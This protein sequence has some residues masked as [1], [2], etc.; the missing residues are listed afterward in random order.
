[1]VA[2]K[3]HRS[4]TLLAL[5]FGIVTLTSRSSCVAADTPSPP[6]STR[7]AAA[8]QEALHGWWSAALK[9]RDQRLAWWRDA[10]FGC[11]IHWGAYSRLGG[12]FED[13]KGGTYSEH[14]MRQL[15]IPLA[16]YKEKVV[17]PF[18][19]EKFDADEWVALIKSAGMRYVVITAKHHDGFAMWPSDAYK[20]D[21]RDNTRFKRDPMQ[22]LSAAC[23]RAGIHFGF[24]YSHA[25]DWEHPDAPGN[26]WDYQNPG[27]DKHLFGDKQWYDL[28]PDILDRVQHYVDQKAI[29]QLQELITR[30]HPEIFWFDTAGK[31]PPSEQIR[32]VKAVRLAD[33][34]VVI[35]G[36][37]AR[38]G[39]QNFGDYL[40]TGDNPAEVR[41]TAGDWECIPTVNSS[42]GYNKFDNGYKTPEFFVQLLV[43]TVA[44]GGNMLLNIGPMGDGQID[45]HAAE[46]LRGIG[47]WMAVNGE[48]IHGA[49]RTP[50]E[51]QAWGDST[52]KGSTLYLHVLTWTADDRLMVGG[53]QN[54]VASAYFLADPHKTPLATERINDKDIL[55][56]LPAPTIPQPPDTVIVL[57]CNGPIKAA[58]G[59]LLATN[60]PENQLLAFD[61]KTSTTGFKYGDGKADRYYLA[62]FRHNTD[63]V[64][65]PIRVD[66][67]ATFN[68]SLKYS[69]TS[70]QQTGTYQLT[71]G[72]QTLEG[73]V[74][75]TNDKK[76]RTVHLGQLT[77]P[78]GEGQL[79]LRPTKIEGGDLMQLFEIT[80]TPATAAGNP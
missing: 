65:W 24:Y 77:F 40:D 70:P 44:K 41:P 27:G 71:F 43:K 76:P 52:I 75:P 13:H 2:R 31:L 59:R 23:H 6:P 54:D 15:K 51:R 38:Q 58:P 57:Q 19:P 64:S 22:E 4:V 5:V 9:T 32:I 10:R 45:P 14:I 47:N 62:G 56:Q 7:D 3:A 74:E 28:H 68:V 36:R 21:I 55:I 39:N 37:A 48:S 73:H 63:T 11:F 61:G 80:L 49:G 33:P 17:A 26:D 20:Y 50:L 8:A 42:Y 1:M 79:T 16:V 34:N 35:N 60:V 12:E 18:N 72:T 30:Y 25:F 53:L 66:A 67:P 29:P 46:I 69:T 78:A